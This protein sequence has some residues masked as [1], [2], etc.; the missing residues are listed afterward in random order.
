[1]LKYILYGKGVAIML[2][3]DKEKLSAY[4]SRFRVWQGIPGIEVTKGGRIFSTFYSGGTTEENENYV[5][6]LKSDDGKNFG[7][8][9]AVAYDKNHRCYDSCLWIDPCGRLWF[10]WSYAPDHAV[11]GVICDDPDADKLVWGKEFKIGNDVMMNKP[12]VLSTGEWLFPIAVWNY[13]IRVIS[14]RFDTNDPERG[15]F[16]Y[17]TCDNGLTFEKLGHADVNQRWYDEHMIIELK[18]GVLAMYV[19]T[20]YGIG[21]SYSYDRGATWTEGRNSGIGGPC[22]RFFIRRLKSGR[23]L[24]INNAN[25]STRN[26]L[27]AMLSEDDGAT[28]KYSLMIDERDDVSYPDAKEADDGYIYI[29]YDRERGSAFNSYKEA[30]AQAREV[31]IAKITENDIINGSV[32]KGGYLKGI[33]S[34]LGDYEGK[35][36]LYAGINEQIAENLLYD[37]TDRIIPALFEHFSI[38]CMNMHKIDNEKLDA[39]IDKMESGADKLTVLREIIE[40]VRSVTEVKR[41]VA[42]VVE[43][44]KEY[45]TANTHEQVSVG[46]IADRFVMSKYYLCHLFKK[47]TGITIKNYEKSIRISKAKKLLIETDKSIADIAAEC[48]YENAC[49]FSEL[50]VQSE[51]LSPGKYRQLLKNNPGHEKD[52]IYNSMLKHVNFLKDLTV[53]ENEN[54]ANIVTMPD[55]K[56]KFLHE[57]A[58]IYYD[59][60]LFAAWYNNRKNELYGET[61]IRFSRSFDL[62]KTW[63]K[64]QTVVNDE[65]GK[66]MYCPPVF[67]ICDNKLYMF[68]NTMVAPD[69]IHSLDLYVYGDDGKFSLV[70]SK[71]IPFKLNTNVYTL[72]DG[73]LIMPGR[74]GELDGFPNIPAVMISDSGK[75]DG[76]WRIVKI[77]NNGYL[78][79]G[80][81]LVHP[82]VSLIV[83]DTA[84]HAFCRNDCHN[85]P[86][87]YISRDN[88]ESWSEALTHDIPLGACKIYSGTLSDGRNYIIG[89]IGSA[90][91]KLAVFLS[92]K[93]SMD[94]D[95]CIVLNDG[96]SKKLGF[97]CQWH[98]PSAC[99]Y[100]GRLYVIYTVTL[101]DKNERGAVISEI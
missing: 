82:E 31:L 27:T 39:L 9:V 45:I 3:T 26:N 40:L 52:V 25:T 83:S 59:G 8:P 5:V 50:F 81:E 43:R 20:L 12:V 37:E 7:E 90:R 44:V 17:K 65:S 101:N 11:Y 48:G 23:L 2:I 66:I 38:N 76:E 69:H 42:P 28:W 78:A 53:L 13:G 98:Y 68:L 91:E 55:E 62:G 63:E 77:Q 6:L 32:S 93:N 4:E 57:A 21:V 86:I 22:S 100:N 46:K 70:S 29:T 92:R 64:P 80:S 30:R 95:T 51:K 34:K 74:V 61:P 41:A 19:R 87:L 97:G 94:F 24:L 88:G 85:V 33:I 49:W 1:M 96:Y 36:D 10:T 56:Y 47:E 60:A 99:E 58:V 72:P 73:R 16:V 79:D 67:G 75:I 14:K 84:I 71:P 89:N 15:S 18:S 54:P 35:A